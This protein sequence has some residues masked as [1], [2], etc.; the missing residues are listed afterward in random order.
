VAF[1]YATLKAVHVASAATSLVL[2]AVRGH[3]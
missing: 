2:F 1:S 3:G